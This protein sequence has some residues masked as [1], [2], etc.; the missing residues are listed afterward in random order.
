MC[1]PIQVYVTKAIPGQGLFHRGD[2]IFLTS[3]GQ[4][5]WSILHAILAVNLVIFFEYCH[6]L[7]SN[8]SQLRQINVQQ[9]YSTNIKQS[10][11]MLYT[12]ELKSYDL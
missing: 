11:N 3:Y 2:M 10:Q 5:N 6:K 1:F 9:Q 8:T 7:F 12:S 4:I